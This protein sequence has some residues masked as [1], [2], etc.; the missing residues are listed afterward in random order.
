[1]GVQ[2]IWHVDKHQKYRGV[3]SIAGE[4][5]KVT[6]DSLLGKNWMK[7]Q[8]WKKKLLSRD[9]KKILLK[10]VIQAIPKYLMCVYKF[11]EL[12]IQRIHS[13]MAK[14]LGSYESRLKMHWIN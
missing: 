5:K 3:S 1:M 12:I 10:S 14:F 7:L 6:F 9:G 2:K 13:A 11:P 4:S 8:G